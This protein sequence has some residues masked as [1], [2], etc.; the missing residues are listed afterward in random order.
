LTTSVVI[1]LEQG[2]KMKNGMINSAAIQWD[3]TV[4]IRHQTLHYLQ[5]VTKFMQSSVG[6]TDPDPPYPQFFLPC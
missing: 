4:R 6:D 5:K 3:R 1:R 2:A